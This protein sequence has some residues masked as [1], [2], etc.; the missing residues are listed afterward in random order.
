MA[1]TPMPGSYVRV[2]KGNSADNDY[3]SDPMQEV[4][5]S[6]AKWGSLARYTV[7]RITDA[8]K[9]IMNDSAAPVFQKKIHGAGGWVTFTP[10][11]IWC[12]VGYIICTALNSDDTV[13][14]LSGKYLTPTEVFGCAT[15]SFE[16]KTAFQECTCYGDLAI[17][18]WPTID[19]WDGKLE[20]FVAKVQASAVSSGG[21]ANSHVK[22]SH[23]AGGTAGNGPTLAFTDT[24]QAT[25]T[26]SIVN[27]DDI[28]VDLATVAGTPVSTANEVIAALNAKAEVIA[29]G[30]LAGLADGE[31]GTGVVATSGPYTLAGGLNAIDY[32]ALKGT[33]PA[34]RFYND[35]AN[36]DMY[37][38]F[39]YVT[40]V[41]LPGG[42]SDVQKASI[43]IQGTKYR[44]YHVR[45]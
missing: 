8:A 28:T 15:L 33:R 25:I 24:D 37:C 22:L 3:S 16:D 26:I 12:G 2:Y 43:S 32:S 4:D 5:L 19:D 39:G 38:G 42:S 18:R 34:F 10:T 17:K 7:Y 29:L 11:E 45:A 6:A 44:L 31:N 1:L 21:N 20:A 23:V 40:D 36:G 27:T 30:L 9:R 35:Y 14:C 13:Q 41:E